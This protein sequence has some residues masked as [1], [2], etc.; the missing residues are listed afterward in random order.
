MYLSIDVR[1]SLIRKWRSIGCVVV[2]M[3]VMLSL[4]SCSSKHVIPRIENPSVN[5]SAYQ[6]MY[7]VPAL[8]QLETI[9]FDVYVD[10]QRLH[11]VLAVAQPANK[12]QVHVYYLFSEDGGHHWSAPQEIGKNLPIP[13]TMRGN[14]IQIASYADT[15]VVLWQSSSELPGMGPLVSIYSVDAGKSWQQAENPARNNAGDQAHIDLAVDTTGSFHAVWLEDPE[16]NGYQ[17]LR[18]ARSV[19][20]GQHWEAP[21]TLDDSTCS[22]CWNTFAVSS[23]GEINLLYRNMQPRDMSL[24]QSQD[25]GLSW[26]AGNTVGEFRWQFDG[27]PHIGGGLAVLT[28][29]DKTLLHSVVWTGVEQKQGLYYLGSENN[30]KTWSM[31]HLLSQMAL[32]GD[33]AVTE[34]QKLSAVWDE[35]GPEGSMIKVAKSLDGGKSWLGSIQLSKYGSNATHPRIV[36]T[37]QGKLA[38][39][40]E[41]SATLTARWATAW[42]E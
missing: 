33:I 24:L 23:A 13:L 16:E 38:M 9:A 35:R 12:K 31:P 28:L 40:T 37:R 32:H 17:S 5:K 11:V 3:S 20:A 7:P 22:C 6:V 26:Q 25:N 30:G 39:W 18:Y 42:V 36:A 27:C 34:D 1:Q 10:H 41:K 19:D 2:L 21:K 14:D 4:S 15:R 29:P 8:N